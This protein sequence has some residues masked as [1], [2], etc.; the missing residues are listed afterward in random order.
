MMHAPRWAGS[1]PRSRLPRTA[2]PPAS[3]PAS[4][5]TGHAP[6]SHSDALPPTGWRR[7][8]RL[9]NDPA[10]IGFTKRPPMALA[11]RR[12]DRARRRS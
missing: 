12:H 2:A 7:A 1:R 6:L 3:V 5:G 4:N 8:H 10:F 9:L 11:G